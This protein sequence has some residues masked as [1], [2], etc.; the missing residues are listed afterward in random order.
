MHLDSGKNLNLSV[1]LHEGAGELVFWKFIYIFF[2]AGHFRRLLSHLTLPMLFP[3]THIHQSVWKEE[4]E[5]DTGI[6]FSLKK[7][8]KK[9]IIVA[10]FLVSTHSLVLN[11]SQWFVFAVAWMKKPVWSLNSLLAEL[12]HSGGNRHI[13]LIEVPKSHQLLEIWQ[14]T[15]N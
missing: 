2:R 5:R 9:E 13:P 10:A 4:R 6:T 1:T 8:K 11:F 7:R 3:F 12:S 15:I 14:L